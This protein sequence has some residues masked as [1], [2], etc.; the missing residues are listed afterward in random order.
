MAKGAGL[1][2]FFRMSLARRLKLADRS[3]LR[4]RPRITSNG[5]FSGFTLIELLVVIAIIAILAAILLPALDRAKAKSKAVYCMNSLR[6]VQLA[7]HMYSADYSDYIA[8]NDWQ[9]EKA[10]GPGQ[11]V[12]GWLVASQIGNADNIDTSLLLDPQYSTIGPYLKNP[13]V[14]QCIASRVVVRMGNKTY[15]L[16][17]QIAMNNFMGYVTVT[18]AGDEAYKIF[19]KTT[20]MTQLGPSDVFVFVDQRDDSINDGELAVDMVKNKIRDVP[21]AYH[22]GAGGVTFAD[23]HAEIHRWRTAEVL[24]GQISGT[25]SAQITEVPCAADNADMLWLRDHATYKE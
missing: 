19:R 24:K 25:P 22:G 7:W 13:S 1:L 4:F 8:G 6:Q 14:Y 5:R 20:E 3:R 12:D 18:E 16:S 21:A 9:V 11:W 17:R 10:H 15:P 2:Q 23:G